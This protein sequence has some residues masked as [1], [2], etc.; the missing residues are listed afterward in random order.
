MMAT[1]G[2]DPELAA[3]IQDGV[4][5][6]RFSTTSKV[7]LIE[8]SSPDLTCLSTRSWHF[9]QLLTRCQPTNQI[10]MTKVYRGDSRYGYNAYFLEG[11]SLLRSYS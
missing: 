10:L 6:G 4:D 9:S 3:T 5:M 1:A 8:V 11:G 7:R 2:I